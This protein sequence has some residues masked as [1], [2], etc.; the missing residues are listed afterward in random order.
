MRNEFEKKIKLA[1]IENQMEEKFGCEFF[2]FERY[3]A[4][5]LRI[6]ARK[7]D[8]HIAAELLR[9]YPADEEV[10]LNAS[11]ISKGTVFGFY[12]ACARRGFNDSYTKLQIC[13]R[14]KGNEYEFEL[15]IDGNEKLE[16][17][18][19]NDQ[20]KMSSSEQSTYKPVR[21]GHIVKDM[22]LPIKRFLCNQIV[23]D[24]GSRSAT[25]PEKIMEIIETIKEA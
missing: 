21:R 4:D 10:P 11:S 24:G 18:F 22:D 7:D 16:R 17:F 12:H 19:T 9:N 6:V 23:Y 20:R 14:N 15:R 8:I 25:E 3:H 1:E 5:G 13:W 2:A